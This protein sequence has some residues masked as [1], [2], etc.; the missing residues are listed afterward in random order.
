MTKE[1][2]VEFFNSKKWESMTDIKK[3][4]F[5]LYESKLCMPFSVFQKAMESV[6]GRPVY[7]HE[8][9]DS[10]KL[11]HEFELKTAKK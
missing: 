1:Q 7:T 3:V 11:K 2:A 6:L 4:K 5:Q 8:F 9:A 10:Q